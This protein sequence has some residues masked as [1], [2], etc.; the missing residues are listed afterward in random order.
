MPDVSTGGFVF[1]D[2]QRAL[3]CTTTPLLTRFLLRRS[4]VAET[5][6][7]E[8]SEFAAHTELWSVHPSRQRPLCS[9][10]STLRGTMSTRV[11]RR[12]GGTLRSRMQ[13]TRVGRLPTPQLTE[14][15]RFAPYQVRSCGQQPYLW[16]RHDIAAC[17]LSG[18]GRSAL[19]EGNKTALNRRPASGW[20]WYNV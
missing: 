6:C 14:R 16:H 18:S 17:F 12:P 10:V 11:R 1:C 19:D 4:P 9:G 20:V 3:A 2:D 13:T 8:A 7:C 15:N 5:Q